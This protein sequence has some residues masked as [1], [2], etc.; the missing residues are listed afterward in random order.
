MQ[1]NLKNKPKFKKGHTKAKNT[2]KMKKKD[3][4]MSWKVTKDIDKKIEKVMAAR[5]EKFDEKFDLV[6]ADERHLDIK[7]KKHPKKK[8][9]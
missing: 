8:K 6:K 9:S 4:G 5:A 7:G 1:K 2:P 3:K